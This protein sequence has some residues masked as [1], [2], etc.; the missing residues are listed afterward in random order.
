MQ[1]KVMNQDIPMHWFFTKDSTTTKKSWVTKEPPL[2]PNP[3]ALLKCVGQKPQRP[4]G[5]FLY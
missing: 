1:N 3:D 4:S 5:K 2:S